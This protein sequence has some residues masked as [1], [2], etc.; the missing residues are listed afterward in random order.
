MEL[1]LLAVIGGLAG[2]I[3]MDLTAIAADAVA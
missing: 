2:T 1:W 3:L